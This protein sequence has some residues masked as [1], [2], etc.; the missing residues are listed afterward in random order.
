[1]RLN[2]ALGD[3][4]GTHTVQGRTPEPGS[5]LLAATARTLYASRCGYLAGGVAGRWACA[6]ILRYSARIAL[7]SAP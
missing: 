6:C 3:F 4:V 7:L 1:M 5:F 2:A